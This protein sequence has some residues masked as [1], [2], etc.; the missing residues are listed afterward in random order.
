MAREYYDKMKEN[1][2]KKKREDLSSGD[3]ADVSFH[4]FHYLQELLQEIRAVAYG[5]VDDLDDIIYVTKLFRD[6]IIIDYLDKNQITS[7]AKYMN[8]LTLGGDEMTRVGLRTRIR[9]II[10][11][12]RQL[13]FEVIILYSLLC[14]Q[15]LDQLTRNELAECCEKRGM[16][17]DGLLKADYLDLMN[18][19]LQL[20]VLKRVPTM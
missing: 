2:D 19:W 6:D 14:I 16:T 7:I 9:S 5:G 8:V 12:D 3:C 10:K 4:S 20:S 15:G 11:E 13:Y 1:A 18:D 17:S